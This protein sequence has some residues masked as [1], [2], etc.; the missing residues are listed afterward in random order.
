MSGKIVSQELDKIARIIE[1]A[2]DGLTI[3]EVRARIEVSR[4]LNDGPS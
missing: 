1:S 4:P 3:H 2:P